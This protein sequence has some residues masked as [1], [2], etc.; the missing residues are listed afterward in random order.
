MFCQDLFFCQFGEG[1]FK[2][3]RHNILYVGVGSHEGRPVHAL[4]GFDDVC[5]SESDELFEG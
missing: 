4:A 2:T 5:D 1:G 3:L